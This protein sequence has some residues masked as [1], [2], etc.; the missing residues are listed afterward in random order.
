MR[1][2]PASLPKTMIEVLNPLAVSA[3][4]PKTETLQSPVEGY[5]V[6][7]LMMCEYRFPSKIT[8]FS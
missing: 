4:G 3:L 7:G 2:I 8:N 5:P 6:A 1:L